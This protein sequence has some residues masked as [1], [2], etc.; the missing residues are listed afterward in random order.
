MTLL[1]AGFLE[2]LTTDHSAAGALF[3]NNNNNNS[4]NNSGSID[5]LKSRN[6]ADRATPGMSVRGLDANNSNNNNNSSSSLSNPHASQLVLL[7]D[8]QPNHRSL[9]FYIRAKPL[10]EDILA[11]LL[12][13]TQHAT[14]LSQSSRPINLK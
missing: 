4:N 11:Q 14:N 7:S 10:L 9:F 5:A 8:I 2:P 1:R 6:R 12:A 3:N 13:N